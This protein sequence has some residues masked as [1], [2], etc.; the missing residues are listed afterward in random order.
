MNKVLAEQATQVQSQN[1]DRLPQDARDIIQAIFDDE[2][3]VAC[4]F[5]PDAIEV[6]LD[7]PRFNLLYGDG[8]VHF[9]AL[10]NTEHYLH[11]RGD[12]DWA[13]VDRHSKIGNAEIGRIILKTEEAK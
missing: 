1:T 13:I 7:N 3:P 12:D 6:K 8:T 9:H 2:M 10:G 11:H 5:P 4:G